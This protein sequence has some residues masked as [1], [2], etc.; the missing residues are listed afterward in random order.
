MAENLIPFGTPEEQLATV[1]QA[2]YNILVGGQS[3]QIG[4]RRLT[5]AD[6]ALLQDMQSKLQAQIAADG[7]SGLFADTVVAVFEGR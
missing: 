4:S 1:N 2:I 5:R 6:L 7:T 3:Y